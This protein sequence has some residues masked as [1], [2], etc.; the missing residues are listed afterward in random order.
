MATAAR[1]VEACRGALGHLPG[2]LPGLGAACPA[3]RGCLDGT[4]C[5]LSESLW[6]C[7]HTCPP[8]GVSTRGPP[9]LTALT[10]PGDLP[11]V[12][13]PKVPEGRTA[14]R[15]RPA[16]PCPLSVWPHTHAFLQLR[17]TRS[18][19]PATALQ[20]ASSL[21]HCSWWVASAR[22]GVG[23]AGC[24]PPGPGGTWVC[25]SAEALRQPGF[26]RGVRASKPAFL[27]VG[28][29]SGHWPRERLVPMVTPALSSTHLNFLHRQETG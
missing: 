18:C 7:R 3:T 21:V 13:S 25:L 24:Q 6:P 14:L 26:G 28:A 4:P 8:S 2:R 17:I 15:A 23:G 27:A 29:S 20:A 10:L 19:S 22:Q 12:Q 1:T 16:G 9:L 5:R 11:R